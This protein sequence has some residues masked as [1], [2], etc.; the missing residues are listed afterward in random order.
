MTICKNVQ[1]LTAYT[2]GEQPKDPAI[3]KLNTNE[4]PYPPS[5]KVAETLKTFDYARLRLYPDP[6][7]MALRSSLAEIHGCTVNQVFIGNGSDEILALCTR[8]FV[9][10]DG[11]IGYFDPSYSLYPV[12][13]EIRGVEQ[14]PVKLTADFYWQMPAGYSASLF[15]ITNP[16]APTSMMHDKA[17][18]TAFCKAFDGAVLIDEAYGDFADTHCMDLALAKDNQNTL[19]MRTFSKSFSLAGLRFGY[20]VGPEPLI[21]A[22]YKIKDSYNMDMLAQAVALAALSDLEYMR[23]NVQ[24][25]RTTRARLT[26]ELT[27]RGWTVCP[28]QT[29][30]LFARPPQKN[31]KE[32]FDALK[33]AKIYVRYFPGPA[34]GDYLRITI[35]TEEQTDKLLAAL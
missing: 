26:Q 10:N 15:Y 32:I 31:A 11:S 22:L 33:S 5:P 27:K 28:S 9:E 34:T 8:A 30:F 7:F 1:A 14:R 35:G 17:T 2:P 18:V 16:N 23:A 20:V 3:V 12:L 13:A 21:H 19:V 24:K 4:N 29:N 6:L 25:I